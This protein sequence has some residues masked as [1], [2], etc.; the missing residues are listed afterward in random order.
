MG[1][2]KLWKIM[3]IDNDIL[4]D[5]EGFRKERFFKMALQ[6]VSDFCFEKF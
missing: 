3:K 2:G 6:N 1:F 4:Q 5:L